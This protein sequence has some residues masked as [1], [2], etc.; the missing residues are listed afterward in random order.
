MSLETLRLGV[1]ARN[2]LKMNP[3]RLHIYPDPEALSRAAAQLFVERANRAVAAQ[4]R[5][6]AALSGGRTPVRTYELLAQAPFRD[7]VDWAQTHVFWGD[8][9]C[10]PLDDPRS[11]AGL[12][13]KTLLNSAPVPQ[14][15]VHPILC[16]DSPGE[17]AAAYEVLLR[18]FFADESHTFDLAFLGLGEDGHTASLFPGDAA[19]TEGERWAVAVRRPDLTRI[20]LTP[21]VFNQARTVAF[22]VEGRD[23]ARILQ[24]VLEG[25]YAPQRL[26]AQLIRPVNGELVWLADQAAAAVLDPGRP[27]VL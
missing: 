19:L 17:A 7:Q 27:F 10:T 24:E 12:A 9:R 6:S 26:P 11:N 21:T 4:G 25:E 18:E 3:A 2:N 8:E 22:L 23:K 5:F 1:L 16:H 14:T 13:Q 20:T 15:Q